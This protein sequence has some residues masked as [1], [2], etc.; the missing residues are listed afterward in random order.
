[1]ANREF[2]DEKEYRYSRRSPVRWVFSHLWRYPFLP[3]IIIFSTVVN[4][5]AYSNIQL[6]VGK[7]FDVI[8]IPGFQIAAL[9]TPVIVILCLALGEGLTGVLRNYS[10]E[11]LA[12]R[13]EKDSREELYLNLLGTRQTF[14]GRQRCF[15]ASRWSSILP[16]SCTNFR[17]PTT[18][19]F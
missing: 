5:L 14:H 16:S 8:S 4:N 6:F 15:P 9:L 2:Q 17:T 13:I 1:M 18:T 7:A 3:L 10:G 19:R 11:F 12:Q